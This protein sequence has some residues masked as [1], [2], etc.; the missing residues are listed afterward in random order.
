MGATVA[1]M[2]ALHGADN[3]PGPACTA[4]N[5]CF[6]APVTNDES[7]KTYQFTSVLMSGGLITSYQ[8]N[9]VPNTNVS[10]AE[11]EIMQWMPKDAT[12]SAL[13]VDQN[14]GSCAMYNITSP[15]LATIFSARSIGDPQ[16][17]LGVKLSY[18]DSN[19]NITYD[20]NN[21]QE[22]SISIVPSNPTV[23]C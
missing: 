7:G 15:T 1:R 16:G 3:G 2:K 13:T 23:T 18:T 14:G 6:G 10:T 11:A 5:S 22:A 9:F 4:A 17:V 20:P 12:M 21:V 8:Q 19:L